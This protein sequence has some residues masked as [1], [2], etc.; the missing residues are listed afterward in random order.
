VTPHRPEVAGVNGTGTSP[1]G[2]AHQGSAV[3][4][5]SRDL[6]RVGRTLYHFTAARY[7][8]LIQRQGITLGGVLTSV[9]PLILDTRWRWLTGRLPYRRNEVRLCIEIPAADVRLVPWSRARFLMPTAAEIL[10]PGHRWEDWWLF[11]GN[12]PAEW[13]V[14]AERNPRRA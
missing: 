11:L 10:E 1:A 5:G 8:G 4:P 14:G 13:I 2:E 7:A 12:V 9:D 6:G 3:S